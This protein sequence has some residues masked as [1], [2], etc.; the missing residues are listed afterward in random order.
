MILLHPRVFIYLR[1]M[2]K[3]V[4]Q[5]SEVL[6]EA[7]RLQHFFETTP[8]FSLFLFVPSSLVSIGVSVI[9][10]PTFSFPRR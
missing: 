2:I 5:H 7:D 4:Q 8:C 6:K 1:S 3:V 10:H 9:L